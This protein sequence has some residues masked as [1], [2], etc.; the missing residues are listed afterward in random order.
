M[1]LNYLKNYGIGEVKN[2]FKE[3]SSQNYTNLTDMHKQK[4]INAFAY[5]KSNKKNMDEI[6]NTSLIS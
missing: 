6:S 5:H 1:V 2:F 3:I 4:L